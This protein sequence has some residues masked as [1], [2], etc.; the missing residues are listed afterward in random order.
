MSEQIVDIKEEDHV[1]EPVET[2]ELVD[3]S[4]EMEE[5]KQ[6]QDIEPSIEQE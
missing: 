1:V 4:D 3:E 6:V 5:S 2:T